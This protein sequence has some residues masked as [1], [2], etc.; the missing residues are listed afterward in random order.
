MKIDIEI[1][2]DTEDTVVTI[3]CREHNALVDRLVAALRIIDRQI[4]VYYEG[5]IT[6]LD[7]EKIMYIESVDGKCFL[8][9]ADK[10]Y[11]SDSRLYELEQQLGQYLF[12]RIN[13]SCIVNLKNVESIKTYLDRRL[14]MT[15]MNGEQ[16]VVSRQYAENIKG[17]LR[18][19]S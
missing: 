17:L 16:L 3:K 1:R 14:L 10:L 8:Y 19:G 13:R 2:E 4:T 7:L 9:T 6:V 18:K 11:G 15:L 12:V 5:K